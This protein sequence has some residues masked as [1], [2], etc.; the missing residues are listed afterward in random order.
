MRIA[1]EAITPLNTDSAFAFL[2][3]AGSWDTVIPAI[4]GDPRSCVA[5]SGL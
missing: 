4:P 1:F 5:F 3:G 2:V